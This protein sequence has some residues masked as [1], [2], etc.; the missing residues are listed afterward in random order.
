MADGGQLE[1]PGLVPELREADPPMV[2]AAKRTLRALE[3]SGRV[4][5]RHAVLVTMVV[6]LAAAIHAGTRS[7]RAS[8]VA[9]A[10]AQLRETMLVLD[11]PPEDGDAGMEALRLMR[12]FMDAVD[13][14]A[15]TGSA[16]L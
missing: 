16:E 3:T 13:R 12:E 9:M 10:A 4:E 15:E 5:D 14:A 2:V 6:E 7:G 1:I 11:P 8:A